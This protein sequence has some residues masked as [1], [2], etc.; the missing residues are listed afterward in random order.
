MMKC[1]IVAF[2]GCTGPLMTALLFLHANGKPNN[3]KA[4]H[5][6]I[7]RFTAKVCAMNDVQRDV[8]G[9]DFFIQWT[10]ATAI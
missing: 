8:P 5:T 2:L 3:K 6:V 1:F 9:Q 10:D 4:L 7:A